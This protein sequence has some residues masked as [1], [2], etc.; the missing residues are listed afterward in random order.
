MKE[1]TLVFLI[2]DHQVLLAMKK[3]GFGAGR[4]NGAG[5]KLEPNESTTEALVR[6]CQ[7]EIGVTPTSYEKV[8][9]LT[10]D[11][12]MNDQRTDLHVHAFLCHEWTGQ[13]TESE[14]MRPQWFK[15]TDIPYGDMWQDD[16]HW[17]PQVLNG[18]KVVGTFA[19]DK[20]DVMLSHKVQEVTDFGSSN[21]LA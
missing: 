4:W 13:P 20:Q 7:E 2:R 16:K 19:F 8:A 11:A 12:Y 3:R 6:E 17:L 10:F 5:G 18:K 1:L 21:I 15:T 9:D 14:E